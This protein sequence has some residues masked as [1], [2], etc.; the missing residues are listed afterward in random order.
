MQLCEIRLWWGVQWC[1]MDVVW[2]HIWVTHREIMN[3][4]IIWKVEPKQETGQMTWR[5]SETGREKTHSEIPLVEVELP[6]LSRFD[7]ST[8]DSRLRNY[9]WGWDGTKG[10]QDSSWD[11]NKK[12]T[13]NLHTPLHNQH[14]SLLLP[15]SRHSPHALPR[16]LF[17]GFKCNIKCVW[18][19]EVG[20]GGGGGIFPLFPPLALILQD[21]PSDPWRSVDQTSTNCSLKGDCLLLLPK[22]KTFKLSRYKITQEPLQWCLMYDKAE[23]PS[24][25]QMR[26]W[27]NEATTLGEPWNDQWSAAC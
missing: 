6:V 8:H 3:L 1:V 14:R 4:I 27:G 24:V 13:S 22:E 5:E 2:V 16:S 26:D 11:K 12:G 23:K 18:E 7:S 21:F 25:F 10:A 17:C 9:A 19:A 20:V 15:S